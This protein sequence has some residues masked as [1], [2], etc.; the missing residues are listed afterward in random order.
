MPATVVLIDDNRNLLDA[1]VAALEAVSDFDLRCAADGAEGLEL[2][3][4]IHPDCVVADIKMPRLDGIQL[5]QAL[6]GDP[7]TVN[8]PIVMMTAL[9]QD[10]DRFAGLALGADIYLTKPVDLMTLLAGIEAAIARG[11]DERVAQMRHMS[12]IPEHSLGKAE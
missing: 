3:F 8:I 10:T 7:E 6:R 4:D 11:E 1:M 2:I 12:E 9:A 5:V